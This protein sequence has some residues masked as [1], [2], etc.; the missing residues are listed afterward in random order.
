MFCERVSQQ[1]ARHGSAPAARLNCYVNV[2][3]NAS[4]AI[5]KSSANFSFLKRL[6][7]GKVGEAASV[8]QERKICHISAA[9]S[10]SVVKKQDC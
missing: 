10:F 3:S 8:G 4:E 7:L 9:R 5:T 1:P 6:S 2:N